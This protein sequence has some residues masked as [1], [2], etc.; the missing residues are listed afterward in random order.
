MRFSKEKMALGAGASVGIIQTILMKEYVDTQ[1]GPIPFLGDYLPYPWGNWSS[2]GNII[3]GGIIFAASQFTNVF[4]G[5]KK[6]E[7]NINRF[8]GMYGLT[9]L[10]GGIMNGIFPI[11]QAPPPAARM[12]AARRLAPRVAQQQRSVAPLSQ[13]GSP[14]TKILA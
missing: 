7:S 6:G 10:V 12:N 5:K 9:N 8:L 2:T 11:A 13:T 3:I 1:F 14:S 4:K